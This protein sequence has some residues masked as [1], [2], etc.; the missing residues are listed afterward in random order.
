MTKLRTDFG[1]KF[2]DLEYA[3]IAKQAIGEHGRSVN[4]GR[5]AYGEDVL[6]RGN[7]AVQDKEIAKLRGQLDQAKASADSY[8]ERLRPKTAGEKAVALVNL[9]KSIKSSLDLSAPG[10]QGWILGLT[11]PDKALSAFGRQ[12]KAMAKEENAYI[13]QNE[14]MNRPMAV[15][16]RG[17]G[18]YLAPLDAQIT[19]GEE[20]FVGNIFGR[21]LGWTKFNPFKGSER[22]Y[23]TYLN[24][25]RAD[26]FD[27]MAKFAG[28]DPEA[29]KAIANYVN[30]AS[31][32]GGKSLPG[33]DQAAQFLN[34]AMFSPR[35]VASRFE[36]ALVQPL[37]KGGKVPLKT[38]ALIL[39]EYTK[40]LGAMFGAYKLAELGGATVERDPTSSDFLKIKTGNTRIDPGAGLLQP[41]VFANRLARGKYKTGTG[42]EYDLRKPT[43]GQ[44][45]TYE[46]VV[47]GFAASK[48]APVPGATWNTLREQ[49]Q[50]GNAYGPKDAL[51]DILA[52][53][54]MQEL[55]EGLRKDG[56]GKEDAL[57]LLNFLGFGVN[58]YDKN[59]KR[60]KRN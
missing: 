1:T 13:V 52:P 16:A 27:R 60:D 6:S 46:S 32:R 41:I 22:A 25:L 39:G 55:V 54:S 59:E 9:P 3:Q 29:L 24:S 56:W 33:F 48:A 8:V 21:G 38:R 26:V 47:T 45:V 44:K 57:G 53:I 30:V 18:L 58:T 40:F 51:L 23:V 37:L 31:G 20:A 4:A 5:A 15:K 12:V 28:D 42:N 49:D 34:N 10:R 14:L 2:N 11:N 17:A 50:I 36:Y 19:K 43:Y 35:F 7:W